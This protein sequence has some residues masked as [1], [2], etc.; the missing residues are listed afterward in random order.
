VQ[1]TAGGQPRE[2][3]AEKSRLPASARARLPGSRHRQESNRPSRP[4]APD[5][6]YA[7]CPILGPGAGAYDR[8]RSNPDLERWPDVQTFIMLT[9]VA[10][11]AMRSPQSLE[12]LERSAM[13]HVRTH[14]PEVRWVATYAVL[15]PC[16]YVDVFEAPNVEIA[17]KVSALVRSFGHASTEVWPATSWDRFKALVREL[18]G[19]VITRR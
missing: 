4:L 9:R 19:G 12:E 6:A 18:P 1:Q 3:A 14:C 17:T 5:R 10:P 15:G 2:R 16:D 11:A 13:D 7:L 8:G